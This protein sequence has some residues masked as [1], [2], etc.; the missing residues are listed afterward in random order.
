MNNKG[1]KISALIG[2][3]LVGFLIFLFPYGRGNLR[4]SNS[5]DRDPISAM[6]RNE[7]AS[8]PIGTIFFLLAVGVIGVLGVGRK[9]RITPGAVQNNES[10]KAAENLDFSDHK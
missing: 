7:S 3:I 5:S 2:I 1:I 4:S 10:N 6:N 8:I 9:K